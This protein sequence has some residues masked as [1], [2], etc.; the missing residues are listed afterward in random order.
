ML[1]ARVQVEVQACQLSVCV[2]VG[3]HDAGA[4]WWCCVVWLD[5]WMRWKRW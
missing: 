1:R 2:C 5:G 4:R 3:R